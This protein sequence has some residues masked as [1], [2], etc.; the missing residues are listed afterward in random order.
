MSAVP[1]DIDARAGSLLDPFWMKM[2]IGGYVG[3]F[4]SLPVLCHQAYAF[5]RPA[6][7]QKEDQSIRIY[8]FGGFFLLIGAI[9]FTHSILPYLVNALYGFIPQTREVLIQADINDYIQH[10]LT[11]Y[12]GF[13]ILFQVPLV[14]FL[15][16]AQDF[17]DHT[18]YTENRKWVV[19]ILLVL[20]AIFSP[21]NV[22]SMFVLFIPLY[23]LFEASVLLGRLMGK[24]HVRT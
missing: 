22:E 12:L 16:I 4:C 23:T 24:R 5:I 21:P 8:L 13:S 14:V 2:R 11:F 20:C 7:K 19:V 10:I 3:T 6:L 18:V 1:E 9:A 17:V 15:S